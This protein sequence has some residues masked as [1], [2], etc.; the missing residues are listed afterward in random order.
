[1][2]MPLK[3]IGTFNILDKTVNN[4]AGFRK[5]HAR[6]LPQHLAHRLSRTS[7][8]SHEHHVNCL[9]VNPKVDERSRWRSW[10]L[11]EGLSNKEITSHQLRNL[12]FWPGKNLYTR[13]LVAFHAN[14]YDVGASEFL[15]QT[16]AL[17]HANT[18]ICLEVARW[19]LVFVYSIMHRDRCSSWQLDKRQSWWWLRHAHEARYGCYDL[20]VRREIIV[21]LALYNRKNRCI[22]HVSSV[23]RTQCTNGSQELFS[24]NSTAAF[25]H[26]H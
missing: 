19:W 24:R 18:V 23:T 3:T 9:C 10:Y 4:H 5:N 13:I 17:Q 22:S 8:L 2:N 25:I 15:I 1:M 14:L 11:H 16:A 7:A 26:G 12:L 20:T 6:W 21:K